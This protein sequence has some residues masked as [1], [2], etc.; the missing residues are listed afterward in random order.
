[1]NWR[2]VAEVASLAEGVSIEKRPP[3]VFSRS[4]DDGKACH[5]AILKRE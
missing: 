4:S 3:M 2:E 1:M 5:F